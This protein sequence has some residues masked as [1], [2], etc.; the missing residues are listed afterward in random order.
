[1]DAK[2]L[3][4][5]L[6]EHGLK[7]VAGWFSGEL[8]HVSVERE[9]RRIAQQLE[10][11]QALGAP[12]MV[13]AETTGT[14]QNKHRRA[15][16]RPP[17]HARRGVQELWRQADRARRVAALGRL[18]DDLSPPHGH[19]RRDRARG[20]SADEP[21]RRGGRPAA[22]HRPPQLR[23]RRRAGDHAPPRQAHQPRPLQ[24]HPRRA[25]S[26]ARRPSTGRSSRACSRACSRCRATA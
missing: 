24:G 7:L 13:Y 8:L 19:R 25:C 21:H 12:V 17:A 26:T 23:R 6:E 11:Y 2:V 1:M 22:R 20:R 18:P 15:A 10:L 9:K 4:P 14:V 16:R 3:G 5:I